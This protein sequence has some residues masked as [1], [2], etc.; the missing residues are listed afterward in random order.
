MI[1]IWDPIYKNVPDFTGFIKY[2]YCTLRTM[3]K[4]NIH[5]FQ[6]TLTVTLW[7]KHSYFHLSDENTETQRVLGG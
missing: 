7:D 2:L 6:L 5:Y 1:P 4:G 3:L